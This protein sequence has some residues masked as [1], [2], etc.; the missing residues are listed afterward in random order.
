MSKIHSKD[1]YLRKEKAFHLMSLSASASSNSA[2]AQQVDSLGFK[3]L[4]EYSHGDLSKPRF[5]CTTVQN[6]ENPK[7]VFLLNRGLPWEKM[8]FWGCLE[9]LPDI[10]AATRAKKPEDTHFLEKKLYD[11]R[12]DK[13]LEKI[14]VIGHS[15]GA[16]VV[17]HTAD[18]PEIA[19]S[20]Y[21]SVLTLSVESPGVSWLDV[22]NPDYIEYISDFH[23]IIN[24]CGTPSS[25][26]PIAIQNTPKNIMGREFIELGFE[27]HGI[28]SLCDNFSSQSVLPTRPACFSYAYKDFISRGGKP[29]IQAAI[30]VKSGNIIKN[31]STVPAT[32]CGL[33]VDAVRPDSYS[34]EENNFWSDL[35][36]WF[37]I[38]LTGLAMEYFF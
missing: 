30:A 35:E 32:I 4:P 14:T 13:D 21:T 17:D 31:M 15:R 38:G 23:S 25:K 8:N 28:Q 22:R 16:L 18:V 12:R 36:D 24:S 19:S 27:L 37:E 29:S 26:N 9:E 1:E 6:K 2:F 34:S 33:L 11:I 3:L 20:Q 10:I 7:E 5:C